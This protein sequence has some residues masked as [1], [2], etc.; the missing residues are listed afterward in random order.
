M[1]LEQWDEARPLFA[2]AL[3][4]YESA[5]GADH[6]DLV[7]VLNNQAQLERRAGR[8]DVAREAVQRAIA[9]Q[10]KALP[11]DHPD[12]VNT[13]Y[14]RTLIERDADDL[15]AARQAIERALA[16]AEKNP[17]HRLRKAVDEEVARLTAAS[18]Q[19]DSPVRP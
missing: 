13:F 10:E 8:F 17:G 7:L 19:G 6:I 9:I 5:R 2:R 15:T 3:G 1:Q 14:E 18:R 12:F 11:A 4:I 16:I